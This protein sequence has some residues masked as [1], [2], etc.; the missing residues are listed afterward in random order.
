MINIFH[1]DHQVDSR[2][3]F[4]SFINN[5]DGDILRLDYKQLD[6]N[7]INNFLEGQSLFETKRMLAISNLFSTPKANLDKII[8][9]LRKSKIDIIIWQNK[10][11]T[12][13]QIKSLGQTIENTFSLN[14]NTFL[15]LR[16]IIPKNYQKFFILYKDLLKNQPFDLLFFWIKKNISQQLKTYS[17]FDKN[18]LKKTY[19]KL[20]ELDYQNKTGKL[21]IPRETALERILLELLS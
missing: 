4:L 7:K 6:I 9:V 21:S 14:K 8:N 11:I 19:L 17:R 10:K 16:E 1:G 12:P 20:I 18:I 15:L 13:T 3:A 5:Y 2:N